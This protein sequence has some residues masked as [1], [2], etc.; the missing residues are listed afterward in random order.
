MQFPEITDENVDFSFSS[1]VHLT[2]AGTRL[3]LCRPGAGWSH[4]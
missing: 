3:F 1:P 2:H 4:R